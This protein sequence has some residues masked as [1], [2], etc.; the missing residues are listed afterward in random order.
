MSHP[1]RPA[2]STRAG[3]LGTRCRT[4]TVRYWTTPTSS[5][6][7]WSATVRRRPGR[8]PR[9]GTPTSS[10]TR[11]VT[12][13]CCRSCTSTGTRSR[14]RR[15]CRASV[16]TS[17]TRCCAGT[18]T[19]RIW[20]R[21][22]IR[23]RCTSCSRPHWTPCSTG[24]PRSSVRPA[25]TAP[26]TVHSGRSSCC[27]RRRA[28]PDR[29]RSTGYRSRARGGRTR[30]RCRRRGATPRTWPRCASGCSRTGRRSCS[31]RTAHRYRP[32]WTGCPPETCGWARTRTPTAEPTRA[33]WS[34]PTSAST[35]SRPATPPRR[36]G[37]WAA[38]CATS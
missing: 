27:A 29:R 1:R 23:R 24:S 5:R 31:T 15:C 3:S 12:A 34:C 10:S 11:S 18:G 26:P 17:W 37:C 4:P 32:L 30:Y 20:S 16:T 33:T 13:R 38:G 7:A 21:A 22:A 8:W 9:R 36:P 2:R 19:S 6:S 14:T 25:R 35:A 28:G